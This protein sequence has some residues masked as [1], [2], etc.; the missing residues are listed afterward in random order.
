MQK[1]GGLGRWKNAGDEAEDED[2]KAARG[3]AQVS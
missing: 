2:G 3:S 1:T